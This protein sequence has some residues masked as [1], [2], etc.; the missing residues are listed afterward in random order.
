MLSCRK[1]PDDVCA[2]QSS[3]Q[4]C[5]PASLNAGKWGCWQGNS[6]QSSGTVPPTKNREN[7]ARAILQSKGSKTLWRSRQCDYFR[8]ETFLGSPFCGKSAS[9]RLLRSRRSWKCR[10]LAARPI[11]VRP[12]CPA[13]APVFSRNRDGWCHLQAQGGVGSMHL[14][15]GGVRRKTPSSA[16][17]KINRSGI[18]YLQIGS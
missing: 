17:N 9:R 2:D 4:T 5:Q 10:G 8:E 14:F 3:S 11:N 1:N 18:R 6:K 16:T 15:S 13:P 12:G 7:V